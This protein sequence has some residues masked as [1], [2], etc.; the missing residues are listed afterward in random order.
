MNF[1]F[2]ISLFDAC[3]TLY[4]GILHLYNHAVEVNWAVPRGIPRP[5]AG[6]CETFPLL[7]GEKAI[8]GWTSPHSNHNGEK[9]CHCPAVK[10]AL[11]N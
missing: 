3:F 8:I 5:S 11:T 9:L 10:S 4:T 7:A 6:C 1:Y 2:F